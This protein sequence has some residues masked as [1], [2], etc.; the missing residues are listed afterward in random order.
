MGVSFL[1][2]RV[3]HKWPHETQSLCKSCIT[4]QVSHL[5]DWLG[6]ELTVLKQLPDYGIVIV[7]CLMTAIVTEVSP[8]SQGWEFD[9]QFF[10]R[11]AHF[12]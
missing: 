11:I 1:P 9:L 7:I 5:S 10:E 12:L 6:S 3:R 8:H 4:R 2:L